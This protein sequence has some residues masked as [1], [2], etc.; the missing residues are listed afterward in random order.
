MSNLADFISA[1][2]VSFVDLYKAKDKTNGFRYVSEIFTQDILIDTSGLSIFPLLNCRQT[3]PK[4]LILK[5]TDSAL[6]VYKV[7]PFTYLNTDTVVSYDLSSTILNGLEGRHLHFIDE[8]R[9]LIG[10]TYT[11][12]SNGNPNGNDKALYIYD[13][14]NDTLTQLNDFPYDFVLRNI[15]INFKTGSVVISG[16]YDYANSK[17][18]KTLISYDV[19]NDSWSTIKDYTNDSNNNDSA[20]GAIIQ[21]NNG[22]YYFW[23]DTNF[24][25]YDSTADTLT[26]IDLDSLCKNYKQNNVRNKQLIYDEITDTII[27]GSVGGSYYSS[28]IYKVSKNEYYS[29]FTYNIDRS[30]RNNVQIVDI[31]G[32]RVLLTINSHYNR[33]S[34]FWLDMLIKAPNTVGIQ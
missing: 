22:Y 2:N 6:N 17:A 29:L 33:S 27:F 3:N 10:N 25:K 14:A 7:R 21:A 1:D 34:N 24:Y 28:S 18:L 8:T 15:G 12:D 19:T 5:I 11:K 26:I 30:Y 13:L 4:N 32:A 9:I 31:D 23:G 20:F 16:G